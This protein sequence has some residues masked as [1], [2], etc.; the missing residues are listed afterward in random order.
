MG[1]GYGKSGLSAS[2]QTFGVCKR[3]FTFNLCKLQK[4]IHVHLH[5]TLATANPKLR[6]KIISVPDQAHTH[7]HTHTKFIQK[8]ASRHYRV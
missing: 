2:V 5:D 3:D 1:Y 6:G 8:T 7:T 4:A